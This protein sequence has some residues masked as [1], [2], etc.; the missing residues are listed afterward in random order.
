MGS[1]QDGVWSCWFEDG[2]VKDCFGTCQD[3]GVKDITLQPIRLVLCERR[4]I[5]Y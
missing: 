3:C 2:D 1:I 4:Q 5:E